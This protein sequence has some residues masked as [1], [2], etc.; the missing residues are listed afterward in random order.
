[1]PQPSHNERYH[2]LMRVAYCI[3]KLWDKRGAL[4]QYLPARC[5]RCDVAMP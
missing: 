2:K 1:M 4:H 5:A 3:L